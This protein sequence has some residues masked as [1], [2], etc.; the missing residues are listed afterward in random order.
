MSVTQVTYYREK[1]V[2]SDC[3][4]ASS[5]LPCF[6]EAFAWRELA[7]FD[8]AVTIITGRSPSSPKKIKLKQEE[9][10]LDLK[11][12]VPDDERPNQCASLGTGNCP[13]S[14]HKLEGY[15]PA[16]AGFRTAVFRSSE[17]IMR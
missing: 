1:N 8:L 2:F 6:L 17:A 5:V 15:L 12:A 10:Y 16:P 9:I 13:T 4:A 11:R 3:A 14:D 7:R